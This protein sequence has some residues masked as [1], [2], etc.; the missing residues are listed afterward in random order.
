MTLALSTSSPR[1]SVCLFES[2]G[3]VLGSR[4]S[5]AQQGASGTTLELVDEV[6][7]QAGVPLEEVR[8]F[9]ADV[10]PGS[11]TG[12]RVAVMLAKVWAH[13]NGGEAAGVSSFDLIEGEIVAVPTGKSRW[14]VR[15]KDELVFE[16][17]EWRAD[18]AT[19]GSE[20]QPNSF[21]SAERAAL[22]RER[23]RFLKPE[24]LTPAYGMDPSISRPKKPYG[25]AGGAP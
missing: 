18:W 9:V 5:L 17:R 13:A 12:T 4:E 20:G 10:G 15:G 2:G 3:C 22:L 16:S 7:R 11:F 24:V 8:R 6:L 23:L 21:P 1:V 25:T 14:L 19:Y